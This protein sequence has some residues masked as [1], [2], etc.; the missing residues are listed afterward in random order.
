MGTILQKLD[1]AESNPLRLDSRSM[2]AISDLSGKLANLKTYFKE[3]FLEQLLKR[4]A[5]IVEIFEIRIS[6]ESK[7][8]SIKDPLERKLTYYTSIN[9][10]LETKSNSKSF[11]MTLVIG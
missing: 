3:P 2:Q 8:S 6:S 10:A 9:D 7:L 4:H 11:D 1:V 5:S